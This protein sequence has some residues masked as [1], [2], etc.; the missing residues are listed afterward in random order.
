MSDDEHL[1]DVVSLDVSEDELVALVSGID[2]P[3]I[4]NL[5]RNAP[6]LQQHVF[7]GFRPSRLP[8]PQVPTKLARDAWGDPRKFEVLV[9]LWIESNPDLLNEVGDISPDQVRDGI[10]E[11]LARRGVENKLQ[12]LWALRLDGREQVQQAL[13]AGLADEII[14]ET[15]G[16][17][18]QVQSEVLAA[19]LETTRGQVA[20]L[21]ET[22]AE[23]ETSLEDNRRL[24]QHKNEQLEAAQTRVT[25]LEEEQ[26]RLLARAEE[27][28]REQQRLEAELHDVQQK[29]ADEQAISA[30]LRQSVRDLKATLQLQVES[31]R[32][33]E[34]QQQLNQALLN[35][36]QGRQEAASLRLKLNRLEQKLDD[37]YIKRDE[38]RERNEML[39]RQLDKADRAKE[40]IIEEK[41][42]L[43]RKLEDLQRELT[44]ARR[45][46]RDQV[47][48]ERLDTLP[49]SELDERWL[50]EREAI[51]NFL[52]N[53]MSSLSPEDEALPTSADKWE[54]WSQWLERETSFVDDVLDALD[55]DVHLGSLENLEQAQQLLAL[56][57]YLLEYT[58]QVMLSAIQESAFPV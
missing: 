34:T 54:M 56:R 58:R 5:V 44:S 21:K 25:E 8:W 57:W 27:Q 9:R 32:Q 17:L 31:S 11:L 55:S 42:K 16:L 30:E 48:Q 52:H 38:E 28:S 13:E 35:L 1:E 14:A 18:S 4:I 29:L 26:K 36:E 20:E 39:A 33:E 10:A 50:E 15:S 2:R 7:R 19:A 53:L 47:V 49:L 43:T 45:Q 6:Y 12:L 22:L 51:R 37:A 23:T 24:L 41:R 3:R 46:L 40:V